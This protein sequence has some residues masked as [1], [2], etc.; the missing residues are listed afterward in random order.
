MKNLFIRFKL[1]YLRLRFKLFGRR[2]S[3]FYVNGADTLPPPLSAEEETA[4]LESAQQIR[5]IGAC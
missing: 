3:I 1:L 5:N 4:A 2:R